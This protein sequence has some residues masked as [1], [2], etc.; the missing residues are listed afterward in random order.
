VGRPHPRSHGLRDASPVPEWIER[1]RLHALAA[2]ALRYATT[3]AGRPA[4]EYPRCGSTVCTPLPGRA[5]SEGSAL[6]GALLDHL[7]HDC[8]TTEVAR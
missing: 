7:F 8:P 2:D 6:H 4:V 1:F 5:T 3:A